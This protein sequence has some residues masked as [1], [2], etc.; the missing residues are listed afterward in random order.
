[1]RVPVLAILLPALMLTAGCAT[2]GG[3]LTAPAPGAQIGVASYYAAEYHGRT[4]ASGA[5]FD[6]R[7]LTAAHPTLPFGT[8][9]RVT[10]LENDRSIVVVITDRGPYGRGRIIDVSS[11][12]ARELGFLRAGTARV[13]IEALGL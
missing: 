3:R 12:A 7:R 8:R 11:R 10:N 9:V 1:M 5:R 2:G 6:P 13:R 4:T